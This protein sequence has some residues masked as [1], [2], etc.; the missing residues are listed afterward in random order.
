MYKV[1]G[2]EV[3]DLSNHSSWLKLS[4]SSLNSLK[5][6]RHAINKRKPHEQ[7]HQILQRGNIFVNT[8]RNI[9]TFRFMCMD[10]DKAKPFSTMCDMFERTL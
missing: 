3:V 2:I 1:T 6:D 5:I 7:E 9:Y 4:S 8:T 10:R